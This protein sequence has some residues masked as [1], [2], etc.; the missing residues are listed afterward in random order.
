MILPASKSTIT[1]FVLVVGLSVLALF[2]FFSYKIKVEGLW[3][4][5]PNL[6]S[7]RVSTVVVAVICFLLVLILT[8]KNGL[9]SVYYAAL[10]VIFSIGLYELVWYNTAVILNGWE[11]RNWEFVALL[12]WVFLGAREVFRTK[13]PKI[14]FALYAVFVGSMIIWVSLGFKFNVPGATSYDFVGESLNVISKFSLPIAYAFHIACAKA[15][16]KR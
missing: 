2:V 16:S 14:S 12:G 3:F 7:I 11:Q 15:S 6:G 13:P 9:K 4:V 1:A 8:R 10:A 5:F